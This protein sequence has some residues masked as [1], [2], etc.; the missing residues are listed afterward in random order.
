VVE[1]GKRSLLNPASLCFFAAFLP[2]GQAHESSVLSPTLSVLPMYLHFQLAI[3]Q[4][5]LIFAVMGPQV[6]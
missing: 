5:S 1:E 3:M 2:V 4:H 6:N